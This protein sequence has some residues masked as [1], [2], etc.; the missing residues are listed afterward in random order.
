MTARRWC[1]NGHD[2][3]KVGVRVFSDGRRVECA[4][5]RADQKQRRREREH[6]P[7]PAPPLR[8]VPSSALARF[9]GQ[10]YGER[11]AYVRRYAERYGISERQAERDIAPILE[12]RP[13]SENIAD[14]VLTL[15]GSHIDIEYGRGAA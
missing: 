8:S 10:G 5:C 15:A 3:H 14:R 4:K 13:V 2:R 9:I 1:R 11:T 7:N 6:D 12:G